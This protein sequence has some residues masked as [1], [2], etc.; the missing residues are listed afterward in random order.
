MINPVNHGR[1]ADGVAKYRV[2]PYVVAADVYAMP[3]HTGRGGWSWYTGSAGWMYRLIVES[4]LGVE[5]ATD[6]L[7]IAPCLPAT[8]KAF[9]LHYRFRETLYRITVTQSLA[10]GPR[11][12]GVGRRG[13]AARRRDLAGRRPHRPCGRR[14]RASPSR[15]KRRLKGVGP[16]ASPSSQRATRGYGDPAI[17]SL[18]E[19]RYRPRRKHA[20]RLRS[21]G[22]GINWRRRG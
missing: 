17:A 7:R 18:P 9:K 13:T 1:T 3:P 8:W 14:G 12:R 21:P 15:R 19:A 6:K 2:E 16:G 4:L 11:I 5:L 22:R 10:R 20:K